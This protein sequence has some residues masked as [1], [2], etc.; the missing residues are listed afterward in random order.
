MARGQYS[1]DMTFKER[2]TLGI[3]VGMLE[4]HRLRG[5]QSS[6]VHLVQDS[7]VFSEQA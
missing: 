5:R 7:I 6:K 2:F 1:K 4:S 3:G